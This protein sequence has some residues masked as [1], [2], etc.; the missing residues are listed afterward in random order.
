MFYQIEE[1]GLY[2]VFDFQEEKI[3][4]LLYMGAEPMYNE[5]EENVRHTYGIQEV[6]VTG[7]GRVSHMGVSPVGTLPG[8]RMHYIG[9]IDERNEWGRILKIYTKDLQT[10]LAG[11]MVYQ[12]YNDIPLV[13]CRNILKN[14]GQRALG[15]E[16]VSTFVQSGIAD[17]QKEDIRLLIP[18]NSWQEELQWKETPVNQLGCHVFPKGGQS[19]KRIQMRSVGSWSSGEYLPM[20]CMRN[21][22]RQTM[23]FWQ[24]EH[25]GGWNWE[26]IEDRG[27]LKLV[28]TGPGEV[29]HH[30]WKLLEPGE[31][32]ESVSAAI[33][34]VK[35]GVDEAFCALTGYRR[36]LRRKNKDNET[37]PVIF[38]D[39]MNC[40][41]A[42]PTTEKELPIIDAAAEIGCEY[43]CIDAGWYTDGR[44]WPSVGEWIPSKNRFPN[45]LK[46]VTDYI[47]A[48]G[49]VPG[50]WLEI[51]FM[52]T[53][54]AM[55]E[56][57]DK[58]W[59]F[60]RHG[61]PVIDRERYHLDF[62]NP[63]VQKY[64][65]SVIDRLIKEYGI[66]YFKIDYNCNAFLGTEYEADSFGNGLL[67][68]NRAYLKWLDNIFADYPDV[69]IENCSSGGMRMDYAM[70]ARH[71]IQSTSDQTDYLNYA[72]IATNA[73]TAVTPEQ[74]AIWS[75]PIEGAD[76]EQIIFNCVNACLMRIHQSGNM[77][78]LS[79][80]KKNIV[81]QGL[82]FY[83][84]IREEIPKSLPFW[85]LGLAK[86]GDDWM[87]LG[88]DAAE[89]KL[90][91]VWRIGG[92]ESCEIPL[93]KYIGKELQVIVAFPQIDQKCKM[94][95]N[96][97]SGM[98]KVTLPKEKMARILE[99]NMN[100]A[101]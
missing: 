98:L 70:L 75:Y 47:R 90:L 22:S 86:E 100:A 34:A 74:A 91:A 96:K 19:N 53:Q 68:H 59:F 15:L 57:V 5:P 50:I 65:R 28:I 24:I 9:H 23:H 101:N 27:K 82:A 2:L 73:P 89:R 71:S 92:A 48:K 80:E 38:N 95:W 97:E 64:A 93:A 72:S 18:H 10:G 54:C 85:P 40:L 79:E 3:P 77:E 51:E 49:M 20:G 11:E 12:F 29:D 37:L 13:R 30:W 25:N 58:S 33:G 45:G 26:L 21:V 16:V 63:E 61:V 99:L 94:E 67:E 8:N 1:N 6:Q 62:R 83:K 81:R 41:W 56:K 55:A 42:D 46:E 17:E 44:W 66:G 39:Y 84:G 60:R 4:H 36:M 69:V 76:E 35:G 88:M 32:F 52:G 31:N 7:E 14:E 43:Y 78:L 87:A